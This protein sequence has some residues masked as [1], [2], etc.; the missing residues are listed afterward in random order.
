M[1]YIIEYGRFV[2]NEWESTI[3]LPFKED[4]D[5]AKDCMIRCAAV[6]ADEFEFA[7]SGGEAV[8]IR[9]IDNS[10][11]QKNEKMPVRIIHYVTPHHPNVSLASTR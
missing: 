8:N 7:T 11:H 6:L 10:E 3:A 9:M 1:N 4:F 2:G 5:I